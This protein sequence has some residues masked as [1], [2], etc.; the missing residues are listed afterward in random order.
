MQNSFQLISRCSK[1]VKSVEFKSFIVV[2][3]KVDDTLYF[4]VKDLFCVGMKQNV[5]AGV[6]DGYGRFTTQ[7]F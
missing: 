7:F 1:I 6:S 4:L 5:N 2:W 3:Q